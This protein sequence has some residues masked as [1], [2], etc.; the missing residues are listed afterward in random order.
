MR[1][2]LLA[3][4]LA[5]ATLGLALEGQFGIH[6]PSTVVQC[7]GKFYVYG[8]GGSALVS[9]DGWTWRRGARPLRAGAAP[10]VIHLGDRYC[11]Y[12]A[13]GSG[14]ATKA[15]IDMIWSKT[16]D[17][18]SPAYK[19]EE[20]GVVASS[21]GVEDCNAIDPGAFLDPTDG[22]LWLTYGS[23]FGYIRLV[24]LDPK[25]GKRLNPNDKP[26]DLAINCEASDMIYRDGYYYL[27]ATHGSC[28]SGS[29][30]GYNIRVGRSRKVTGPYVDAMGVDMIQGGGKL[31]AGSGGR[32]I[33]PGHFGLLDLGDGVQ[34]VSLHWE[35]DLDKGG[36]SVL[37]IRPLLWKDGWPIAGEN[38]KEGT[39]EIESVRTGTAL[40]LAVEGVPVGGRRTRRFG[41]PPAGTGGPGAPGGPPPGGGFG[42]GGMFGGTG[43]PI[44]AQDV[45]E[46]SAKWPAGNIDAR[47]S[48]YLCQAQQ[49]WA[50]TAV[51]NAGGYPGSPY[52]KIAIAGTNRVLAATEDAELVV[53]AAFTG[54]DEQLWRLD[55]LADGSWRIMPKAVPNSKQPLS[56]SAVGA[57]FAT[58][59]KFDPASDKQ[60]WL[61]KTP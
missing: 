35:A 49:K 40:E 4:V 21:D 32:L 28:C 13:L 34:K 19:W 16:L 44:P 25:T 27:L 43:S 15:S 56:L 22:R 50:I 52:F 47:M 26:R 54:G 12:V 31:L 11:M 37:D 57:S 42:G 17:P 5:L 23:Y 33:G 24:E 18:N 6:D 3:T 8:T 41:P 59:A 45:A 14:G 20:G 38:A 30:S 36:A 53:L 46:V 60:R 61:L 51:P 29:D 55:Q 7:D 9:D 1:Y 48:N 10:D 58:L 39:Y 2:V